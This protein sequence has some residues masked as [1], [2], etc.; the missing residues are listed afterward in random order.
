MGMR[1]AI[2]AQVHV[3]EKRV[4][5]V[6]ITEDGPLG[7]QFEASAHPCMP[8][9]SVRVT[10]SLVCVLRVIVPHTCLIRAGL[11]KRKKDVRE[12]FKGW[13]HRETT[14]AFRDSRPARNNECEWKRRKIN[15]QRGL[16]RRGSLAASDLGVGAPG[17][18]QEQHQPL[19]STKS[20][21]AD[22]HN[23]LLP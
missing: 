19:A 9:R 3:V 16:F 1:R 22:A 21:E 10:C 4:L 11:R 23:L 15:E 13:A 6:K 18:R 2:C 12:D 7:G 20:F 17:Q 14:P 8:V 5:K